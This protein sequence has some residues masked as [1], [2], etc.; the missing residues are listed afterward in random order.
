MKISAINPVS[1]QAKTPEGNDY[2]KSYAGTASVVTIV[3]ALNALPHIFKE[4][5]RLKILETLSCQELFAKELPELFK[6]KVSP[7]MIK[8]LKALGIA[9]DLTTAY[10][11]GKM[12]DNVVN[13][14]R[15]AKADEAAK[16][17]ETQPV[18]NK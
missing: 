1:F 6:I 9:F 18:D 12:I 7:K 14:K 17:V 8:P 2:K 3:A 13:Q 4:N 5:K 15:V 10:F 16:N 11:I